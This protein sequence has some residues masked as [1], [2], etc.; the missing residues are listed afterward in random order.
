MVQGYPLPVAATLLAPSMFVGDVIGGKWIQLSVNH[1]G[2]YS[3]IIQKL[4]NGAT[5]PLDELR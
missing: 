4:L 3:G 2:D 5:L 1:R